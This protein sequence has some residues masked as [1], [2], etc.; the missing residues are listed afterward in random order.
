MHRLLFARTHLLTKT[1]FGD[2]AQR[3]RKLLQWAQL[4]HTPTSLRQQQKQREL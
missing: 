4:V 3:L 1:L 2:T